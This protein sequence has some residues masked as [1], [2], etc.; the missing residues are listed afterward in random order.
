M[1][2][3]PRCRM[4]LRA[5]AECPIC[6]E[7][8]LYEAPSPAEREKILFNRYYL[9]YLFRTVWFSLACAVFVGVRICMAWPPAGELWITAAVLSLAALLSAVFQRKTLAVL[10]SQYAEWRAWYNLYF[11]KYIFAI[12]AVILSFFF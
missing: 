4:T 8:L 5:D 7:S 6:G 9:W 3:C 10:K 12:V 1:K 2:Q 11:I